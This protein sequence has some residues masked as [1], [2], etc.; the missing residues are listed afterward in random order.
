MVQKMQMW[1]AILR[2]KS[3]ESVLFQR[4]KKPANAGAVGISKTVNRDEARHAI[5]SYIS[6]INLAPV[7]RTEHRR[8]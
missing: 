5:K 8:F 2:G 7:F 6:S 4:A 1:K 3:V